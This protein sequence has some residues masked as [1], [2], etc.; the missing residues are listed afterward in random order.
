MFYGSAESSISECMSWIRFVF[1]LHSRCV[2]S[3]SSTQ[4]V[5][6]E[7]ARQLFNRYFD[8]LSMHRRTKK[9]G[10]STPE[11]QSARRSC[12]AKVIRLDTCFKKKRQHAEVD[13]DEK[14]RF[15]KCPGCPS[16]ALKRELG[17]F[18]CGATLCNTCKI[19]LKCFAAP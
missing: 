10:S 9:L 4:A 15:F 17:D 2:G 1:L 16:G 3:S 8:A 7:S 13:R 6:H 19:T 12:S 18:V 14:V 11:I 5:L